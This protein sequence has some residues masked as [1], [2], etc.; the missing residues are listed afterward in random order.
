MKT[1]V[2][3]TSFVVCANIRQDKFVTNIIWCSVM[4][5]IGMEWNKWIH[6]QNQFPNQ[7][8]TKWRNGL[9]F[10]QR[11]VSLIKRFTYVLNW[12]QNSCLWNWYIWMASSWRMLALNAACPV[13]DGNVLIFGYFAHDKNHSRWLASIV[14]VAYTQCTRP[15]RGPFLFNCFTF[16]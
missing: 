8:I 6:K 14:P 4:E 1:V 15:A 3:H 2:K 13:P 12:S 9:L 5:S 7:K 10:D 11:L 16:I